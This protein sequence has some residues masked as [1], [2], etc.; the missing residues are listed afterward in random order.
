MSKLSNIGKTID[1][2][3]ILITYFSISIIYLIYVPIDF[4]ELNGVDT[5]LGLNLICVLLLML[6]HNNLTSMRILCKFIEGIA[7]IVLNI[8][9]FYTM[10]HYTYLTFSCI[11]LLH[12]PIELWDICEKQFT[13]Q[14]F[15]TIGYLA[16]CSASLIYMI[17]YIGEI[18]L[19]LIEKHKKEKVKGIGTP[20]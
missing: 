19:F 17:W 6:T 8:S 16:L 3:L 20:T 18:S 9:C 7:S 10:F 13:T 1:I 14:V 4:V 2:G 11:T 5:H 12:V 15:L